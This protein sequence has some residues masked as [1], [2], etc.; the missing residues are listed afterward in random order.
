MDYK[1]LQSISELSNQILVESPEEDN[2]FMNR[3]PYTSPYLQEERQ[4]DE[5]KV[6][7]VLQQDS[8][9]YYDM[10]L[11]H[12]MEEG[13]AESVESA[14]SIMANM[15]EAWFVSIVESFTEG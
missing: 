10:I 2:D 11:S 13:Y 7:P 4:G 15:S 14:H 8:Y 1:D 3:F 12:L 9:D 5:F 6:V